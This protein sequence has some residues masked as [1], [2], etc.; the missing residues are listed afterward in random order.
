MKSCPCL[1][2]LF[3]ASFSITARAQDSAATLRARI[4]E[5][6]V[7]IKDG[8]W[9]PKEFYGDGVLRFTYLYEPPKKNP[10]E[11]DYRNGTHNVCGVLESGQDQ[12]G[13]VAV[14]VAS[15]Y[16]AYTPANRE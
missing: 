5:C 11:Y 8:P 6:A 2:L 4:P 7:H 10:G 16:N 3:A 12:R 15:S 13:A 14:P 9:V 1:V